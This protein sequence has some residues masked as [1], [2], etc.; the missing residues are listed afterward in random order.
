MYFLGDSLHQGVRKMNEKEKPRSLGLGSSSGVGKNVQERGDINGGGSLC[1]RG[2]GPAPNRRLRTGRVDLG[3]ESKHARSGKGVWKP[4]VNYTDNRLDCRNG[5]DIN[6]WSRKRGIAGAHLSVLG[7]SHKN[8]FK[9][10]LKKGRVF[11]VYLFKLILKVLKRKEGTNPGT[12]ICLQRGNR[13]QRG[14][15]KKQFWSYV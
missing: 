10:G 3:G 13:G 7:G 2:T 12:K 5:G 9:P 15:K 14:E 8:I 4:Q 11:G 6:P 1:E